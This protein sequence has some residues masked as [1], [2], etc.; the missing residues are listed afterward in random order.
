MSQKQPFLFRQQFEVHVEFLLFHV[1][2]D[3]HCNLYM[4]QI[5]ILRIN[6]DP[7]GRLRNR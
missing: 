7:M 2:F 5:I 6:A 4:F 1:V 3:S